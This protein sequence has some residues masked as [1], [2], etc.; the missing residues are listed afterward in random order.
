[1]RPFREFL[2]A[3]ATMR[4]LQT[5]YAKDHVPSVSRRAAKF[6]YLVDKM[7]ED[8]KKENIAQKQFSLFQ[9]EQ[10]KDSVQ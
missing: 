8:Y 9:N 1:M 3:V 5:T 6:E 2:I 4:Q 10:K 7:L